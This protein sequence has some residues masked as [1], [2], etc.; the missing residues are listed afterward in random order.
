[1]FKR[2]RKFRHRNCLD[3]D[4]IVKDILSENEEFISLKVWYWNRNYNS[5]ATIKIDKV[6][7]KK[8]DFKNWSQI[9]ESTNE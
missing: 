2:F 5:L 7:V 3:I 4:I 6:T 1:M 8:K 9:R